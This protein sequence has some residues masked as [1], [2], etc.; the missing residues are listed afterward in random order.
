MERIF[1][2]QERGVPSQRLASLGRRVV[3]IRSWWQ[4]ALVLRE[5][6]HIQDDDLH[7]VMRSVYESSR[8]DPWALAA[9]AQDMLRR[10]WVQRDILHE[11]DG[12]PEL[13]KALRFSVASL[14]GRG[15]ESVP[16]NAGSIDYLELLKSPDWNSRGQA[17]R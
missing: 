6:G 10:G 7:A 17:K 8:E 15:V 12:P 5:M 11:I 2:R 13:I 3:P 1:I 16:E 14:D 4:A 9:L